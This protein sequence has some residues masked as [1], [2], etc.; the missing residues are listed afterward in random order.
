MGVMM[1]EPVPLTREGWNAAIELDGGE[2]LTVDDGV[3]SWS[4]TPAY[5]GFDHVDMIDYQMTQAAKCGRL[6]PTTRDAFLDA[7]LVWADL[8]RAS[9]E[10]PR[11]VQHTGSSRG[12]EDR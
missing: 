9:V 8:E 10:L 12:W 5:V 6:W 2:V 7:R 3:A 4:I 1:S 11:V